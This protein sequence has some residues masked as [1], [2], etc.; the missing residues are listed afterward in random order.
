MKTVIVF[1]KLFI[2]CVVTLSAQGSFIRTGSTTG[3]RFFVA[4]LPKTGAANYQKLKIEVT[5]GNYF[6][7]NLGTRVYTISSRNG[8]GTNN[9]IR[10]AQEQRGGATSFYSLKVYETTD[11]Y[12]FIIES[13]E[14]YLSIFVQAWLTTGPVSNIT[15]VTVQEVKRYTNTS[16]IDVT[17]QVELINVYTTDNFGNIGIGVTAPKAKLD[18]N[19]V[20][21][22]KEVKIEATGW[23][24]FVFNEDYKLPGLKEIEA[25]IKEYKHLPDIP[26]EAEVLENG[27]TVG[28]MQAKLLQKIEELTLYVIDQD[29]KYDDLK[30]ENDAIK[31]ELKLLKQKK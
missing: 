15:P 7:D 10:V 4:S 16:S 26:S 25:H 12:D 28:E 23:S 30:K 5:G 13:T 18:V 8:F 21:R 24:D 17:S 22:S 31:Q 9:L 6:N 20:I 2:I 1:L 19:G 3:D 29:K 27:I 14:F 11:A